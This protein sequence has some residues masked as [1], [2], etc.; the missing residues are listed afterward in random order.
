VRDEIDR[1][2]KSMN[3]IFPLI[4]R[5]R[6]T[7]STCHNPH[8]KEVMRNDRSRSGAGEPKRLRMPSPM[9]CRGCHSVK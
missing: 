1:S 2:E 3:V 9:I 5:G 7:C 8:Q 4:P 6:I